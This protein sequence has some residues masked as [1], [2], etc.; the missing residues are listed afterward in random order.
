MDTIAAMLR[1]LVFDEQGPAADWPLVN[2]HLLGGDDAAVP[3][4][5]S[6]KAGSIV[7]KPEH[8]GPAIALS[9]EVDA[10]KAGTL[11]LQTCRLRQ[12]PE[13]YRLYEE[14]ARHRLKIYLEKSEQWGLLDPDR[15]PE[16]FELFERAREA[17]VAGM[18]ERDS[19]RAEMNHREALALATF[20]TE[21]LLTSRV[22]HMLRVRF[23]RQ[24]AARAIGVRVPLEK[25]PEMLG[26]ALHKEF[27][28]VSVPT[29]WSVIEPVQGRFVWDQVDRWMAW[30]KKAGRHV[31]AG[32]LLDA[33]ASGVPGWVRPSLSDP[34]RIRDRLHEFVS[35]VVTRYAPIGPVWNIASGVNLNQAALLSIDGM[36][37]VTRMAAVSVRQAQRD[38][39]LLIEVGD[40][41]NDIP[42][43][44]DGRLGPISA[45]QYLRV[46]VAAGVPM[47]SVGVPILI[48]ESVPGRGSRDLM[49]VAAMLE[50]FTGP[51]EI[52]PIVITGCGAPSTPAGDPGSGSWREPWSLRSQAAWAPLVFQIAMA[53]P[54]IHAVVWDR[55]RDDAGTGI[56][57]SGLFMADGSPKPAAER[58]LLTR[59]RLRTALGSQA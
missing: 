26:A 55:L 1:F 37:A 36:V 24:G 34:A 46:L 5:V 12:R 39:K 14:L 27:D 33:T 35:Q 18:L 8:F 2:A 9:L 6:F 58:L 29:P 28:I 23:G 53:N 50:R 4:G 10:G 22:E 51:K 15:A 7:C 30:A 54:G 45:I 25:A 16:A 40:P 38:A 47:D 20:A 44:A 49:Q 21:R 31:I 59:R 56:R 32:P 17:F 42:P 43:A 11:M 57:H 41:F 52:P 3:G 13:P 19:F 48:G